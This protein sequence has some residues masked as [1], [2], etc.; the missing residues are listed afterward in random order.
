MSIRQL[1]SACAYVLAAAR[2][3]LM[4]TW[5]VRREIAHVL[6]GLSVCR[7]GRTLSFGA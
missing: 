4:M 6:D 3:N 2:I 1:Q 7:L 5:D